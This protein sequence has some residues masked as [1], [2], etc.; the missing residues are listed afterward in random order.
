MHCVLC[1]Y[2][3]FDADHC[4]NFSMTAPCAGTPVAVYPPCIVGKSLCSHRSRTCTGFEASRPGTLDRKSEK[5]TV[6]FALVP[7]GLNSNTAAATLVSLGA[8]RGLT[9]TSDGDGG[10][11]GGDV[12]RQYGSEE[13]N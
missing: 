8:L 3:C 12:D 4:V 6:I 7:P 9:H 2:R 1:K 11:G 13:L 10:G 5:V